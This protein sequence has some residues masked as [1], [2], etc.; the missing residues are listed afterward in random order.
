MTALI[1]R[2]NNTGS[3]LKD[4]EKNLIWLLKPNYVTAVAQFLL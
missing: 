2:E 3:L 4:G 1:L